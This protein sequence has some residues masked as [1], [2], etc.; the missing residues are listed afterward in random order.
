MEPLYNVD[1]ALRAFRLIQDRYPEARFVVGN[2][3]PLRSE[4]ESLA[5]ELG[6]KDITFTGAVRRAGWLSYTMQPMSM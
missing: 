6:L 2:D 3:G 5:K 4:L 1:C